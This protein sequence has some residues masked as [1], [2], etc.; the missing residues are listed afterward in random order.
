MANIQR[1]KILRDGLRT[2]VP[3]DRLDMSN[4]VGIDWE[5]YEDL[6]CGTS[7]C[8]AGWATTFPILRKEGLRLVEKEA[9]IGSIRYKDCEGFNALQIF[10]ELN[11]AQCECIFGI[12][13]SNS[14]EEG[15]ARIDKIIQDSMCDEE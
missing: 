12:Q 8:I 5:G 13:N 7:A 6:R 4:W 10:F 9:S 3:Q 1:L 15:I 14:I 2:S 11:L